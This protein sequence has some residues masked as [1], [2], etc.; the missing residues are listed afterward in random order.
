MTI[1]MVV[2]VTSLGIRRSRIESPGGR[3]VASNPQKPRKPAA[4]S[5]MNVDDWVRRFFFW[6]AIDLPRKEPPL[7]SQL[8]L[9][10]QPVNLR[11]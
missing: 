10:L 7:P 3:I 4:N 9:S 8:L 11:L 6:R 5:T 2:N 1:S